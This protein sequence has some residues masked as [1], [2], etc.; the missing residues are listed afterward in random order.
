M[1][2]SLLQLSVPHWGVGFSSVP[3]ALG[4][5]RSLW[6]PQSCWRRA[7]FPRDGVQLSGWK[8]LR[9]RPCGFGPSP[10]TLLIHTPKP[11]GTAASLGS[12]HS[13][14]SPIPCEC[15]NCGIIVTV[16][17]DVIACLCL[18]AQELGCDACAWHLK[19]CGGLCFRNVFLSWFWYI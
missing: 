3:L 4:Y 18:T 2:A 6:H 8:Q 7:A 14:L 15:S 13:N 17:S 9:K 5:H 11:R 16:P 10:S 12:A 19:E 1:K